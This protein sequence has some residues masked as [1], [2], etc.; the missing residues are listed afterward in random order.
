[1]VDDADFTGS[2]SSSVVL[3]DSVASTVAETD[4]TPSSLTTTDNSISRL[5]TACN[6]ADPALAMALRSLIIQNPALGL[7]AAIDADHGADE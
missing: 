3:I 1:M 2:A 5:L 6:T 4:S 7:Q